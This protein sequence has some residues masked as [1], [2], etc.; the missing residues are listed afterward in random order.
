MK[1]QISELKT[2]RQWRAATGFDQPRFE[3]LLARFGK[4]Y[5]SLFGRTVVDRH[6]GLEITPHL[7]SEEELLLFTLFSLKA[8]LTYDLLGLVCGMDA[9]NAKRNQELGLKVLEHSLRD[10][11]CLPKREFKDVAEF[12]AYL[13]KEDTLIFDGTEQRMQRPCEQ[14]AQADHYSGKKSVT[15]PKR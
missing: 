11:N 6:A 15:R 13:E 4:S 9:S 8:G 1:L 3:K 14:E 5:I 10:A 12:I 7:A 2:D